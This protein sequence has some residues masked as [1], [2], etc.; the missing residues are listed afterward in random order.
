MLICRTFQIPVSVYVETDDRSIAK[1]IVDDGAP[2]RNGVL[3]GIETESFGWKDKFTA[4][5][6]VRL[7]RAHDAIMDTTHDWPVWTLGF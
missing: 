2:F 1:V 6:K 5:T 3:D 7:A 4:A